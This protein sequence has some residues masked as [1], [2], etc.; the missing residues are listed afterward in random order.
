VSVTIFR[1]ITQTHKGSKVQVCLY[2]LVEF[3]VKQ[4]RVEYSVERGEGGDENVAEHCGGC[5]ANGTN[6]ADVFHATFDTGKMGLR[7]RESMRAS[8]IASVGM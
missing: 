3:K 5:Y 4:R 6:S 1:F 8:D 7:P 2:T